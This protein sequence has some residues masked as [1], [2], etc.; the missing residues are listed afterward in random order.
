MSLT[1]RL[2][3]IARTAW[4]GLRQHARTVV[5]AATRLPAAMRVGSATLVGALAVS[6]AAGCGAAADD[7]QGAA[8]RTREAPA[9]SPDTREV[10]AVATDV[11][12]AVGVS[13]GFRTPQRLDE[14]YAKHGAEFGAGTREDYLR[15]AQ[16]LRDAPVGGAVLE[17]TRGD[18]A[19]SRFDRVSGA[20]LAFD[21][22]GTIRTFFRP[23]DGEAYFRRQALRRRNP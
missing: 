9:A 16:S 14:H 7:T 23:N 18:G 13:I 15:Q 20:F 2:G 1:A 8:V 10:E 5:R 21:P 3:R 12:R 4:R 17:V 19:V 11:R 22:D 6:L